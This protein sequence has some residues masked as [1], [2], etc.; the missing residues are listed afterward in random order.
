MTAHANILML[1]AWCPCRSLLVRRPSK[2][3]EHLKENTG[4]RAQDLLGAMAQGGPEAAVDSLPL[5]REMARRLRSAATSQLSMRA[6]S[7]A[8]RES[9]LPTLPNSRRFSRASSSVGRSLRSIDTG[10]LVR[11]L[12]SMDAA[13]GGLPSNL[14]IPSQGRLSN[15]P[16]SLVQSDRARSGSDGWSPR[17][18]GSPMLSPGR[19]SGAPGGLTPGE[20]SARGAFAGVS[21]RRPTP[22]ILRA[23]S[24][25]VSPRTSGFA[26]P[27]RG[28]T[29]SGGSS[30]TPSAAT[31]PG[32]SPR[33]AGMQQRRS[34]ARAH[35]MRAGGSA[36]SGAGALQGEPSDGA[37]RAAQ[38]VPSVQGRARAHFNVD[39]IAEEAPHDA[40]AGHKL[41]VAY[42]PPRVVP[43]FSARETPF[44]AALPSPFAGSPFQVEDGQ[45]R[46]AGVGMP[47]GGS[48]GSGALLDADELLRR[49][50]WARV[51][52]GTRRLGTDSSFAGR[53]LR[54][55]FAGVGQELG[56]G[57]ERG[58]ASGPKN[59]GDNSKQGMLRAF[60]G[61]AVLAPGPRIRA[62]PYT[63]VGA[64]PL[65]VCVLTT[66]LRVY[67]EC[68]GVWQ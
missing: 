47:L 6:S 49:R 46:D 41:G 45:G 66:H 53:S 48:A 4:Q 34:Y 30:G 5:A 51:A 28:R 37:R 60:G 1:P 3:H 20:R 21:P 40:A 55:S 10:M 25:G 64:L 29:G 11:V 50:T 36:G 22:G 42:A 61:K 35:S 57:P 14:R 17:P 43:S 19:P 59:L 58:P 54:V 7:L 52:G 27:P 24:G 44:G 31:S 33:G 67:T 12:R 16:G 65:L 13:S 38:R 15:A 32:Q 68:S 8:S 39:T 62:E 2:A 23:G 9:S 18:Q 26:M 56:S 63:L